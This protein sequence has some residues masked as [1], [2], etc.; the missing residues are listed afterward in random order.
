MTESS[1]KTTLPGAVN[2]F[3]TDTV[4]SIAVSHPMRILAEGSAV[5]VTV[6]FVNVKVAVV[7]FQKTFS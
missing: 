3:A 1:T 5:R 2:L 4:A 6:A 7:D